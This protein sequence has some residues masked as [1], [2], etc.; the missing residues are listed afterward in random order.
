MRVRRLRGLAQ[1]RLVLGLYPELVL[2]AG[3]QPGDLALG[4]LAGV[5]FGAR[6]PL[7]RAGLLVLNGV[8]GD[9]GAVVPQRRRPLQLDGVLRPVRDLGQAGRAGRVERV[10]DEGGVL[11]TLQGLGVALLV[12]GAD[13]GIVI[14]ISI[15]PDHLRQKKIV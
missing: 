1:P 7:V 13:P 15:T 2:L 14:R 12:A 4:E 8:A 11:G 5:D 9:G 3:G 6:D 10:L